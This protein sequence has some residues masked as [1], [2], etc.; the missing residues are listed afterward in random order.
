LNKK[1]L[2]KIGLIGIVLF[3]VIAIFI[4][5]PNEDHF[6]QWLTENYDVNCKDVHCYELVLNTDSNETSEGITFVYADGYYDTSTGFLNLSTQ[7]KRL[8]RNIE[9]PNQFFSIE[10]RGF[11]GDFKEIGFQ[12]NK[13][14]VSKN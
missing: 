6:V 12:Q 11:F 13:V 14:S 2:A 5:K 4:N 7:T 8:Y 10:V 3:G 9:D 1:W